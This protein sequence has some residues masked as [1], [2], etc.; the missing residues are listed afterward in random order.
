M[1]EIV[2]LNAGYLELI[3]SRDCLC[4]Q[5]VEQNLLERGRKCYGAALDHAGRGMEDI[6]HV[7]SYTRRAAMV[8]VELAM[9]SLRRCEDSVKL[10]LENVDAAGKSSTYPFPYTL[11]Q[12]IIGVLFYNFFFK[13]CAAYYRDMACFV[14]NS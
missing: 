6:D 12:R 8:H 5:C 11:S 14:L 2:S 13:Y 4:S 3:D 10:Q 1:V 7:K 9:L